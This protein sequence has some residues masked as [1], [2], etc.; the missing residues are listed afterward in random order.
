MGSSEEPR[1]DEQPVEPINARGRPEPQGAGGR[2]SLKRE[3]SS[4]TPC[5]G[6][7]RETKESPAP[8]KKAPC[9]RPDKEDEALNK[10]KD[11]EHHARRVH[12]PRQ[13]FFSAP[14]KMADCVFM[15]DWPSRSSRRF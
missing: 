3:G 6:G 7:E 8:A 2:P 15:L 13:R 9:E 10:R 1:R 14:R 5:G 11:M 12:F 4:A